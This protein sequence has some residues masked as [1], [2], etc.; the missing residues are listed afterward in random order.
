MTTAPDKTQSQEYRSTSKYKPTSLTTIGWYLKSTCG[1]EA[2]AWYNK[3]TTRFFF[4]I[5]KI[6]SGTKISD[7]NP[8]VI[9]IFSRYRTYLLTWC[10]TITKN[11]PVS[12][13]IA[14]FTKRK[15]SHAYKYR[16]DIQNH[17]SPN[18]NIAQLHVC[19]AITKT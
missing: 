5:N 13:W 4:C 14:Y 2:C 11:H 3:I 15:I 8:T 1:S 6:I 12:F 19:I 10:G 18:L 9:V 17:I 7:I 16:W